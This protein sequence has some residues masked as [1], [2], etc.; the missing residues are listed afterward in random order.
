MTLCMDRMQ[1]SL[2]SLPVA[3]RADGIQATESDRYGQC[4][5]FGGVGTLKSPSALT[6]SLHCLAETFL[7]AVN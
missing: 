6:V 7:R 5:T 2:S 3:L 4:I 1:L